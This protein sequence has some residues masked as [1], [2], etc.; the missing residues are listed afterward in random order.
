MLK[1]VGILHHMA[2]MDLDYSIVDGITVR[3][4]TLNGFPG[5]NAYQW[6]DYVFITT[7]SKAVDCLLDSK[8]ASGKGGTE[9]LFT[10]R[11]SVEAYLDRF[12]AI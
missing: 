7:G 4:L 1:G 5:P 2:H 3:D 9:I 6:G 10:N 12:V 11:S 8:W